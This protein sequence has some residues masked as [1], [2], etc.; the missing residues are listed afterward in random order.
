M[1]GVNWKEE[2]EESKQNPK[3]AGG[4]VYGSPF[5]WR[6]SPMILKQLTRLDQSSLAIASP[7]NAMETVLNAARCRWGDCRVAIDSAIRTGCL[8]P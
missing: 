6:R 2:E 7:L 5:A 4:S 3:A 1:F 8:L